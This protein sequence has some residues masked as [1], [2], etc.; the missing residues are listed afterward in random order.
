MATG[1]AKG[2]TVPG[3]LAMKKLGGIYRKP[4]KT[5]TF[6]VFFLEITA[7]CLV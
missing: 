1:V 3:G 7:F 2:S 4:G 6:T 5:K